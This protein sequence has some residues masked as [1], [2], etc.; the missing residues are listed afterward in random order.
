M[1]LIIILQ[2]IRLFSMYLENWFPFTMFKAK[3]ILFE[4]KLSVMFSLHPRPLNIYT[5]LVILPFSTHSSIYLLCYSLISFAVKKIGVNLSIR[6][7]LILWC[8][9]SF[10]KTV[11]YRDVKN[12][13]T[14]RYPQ[15]KSITGRKW[16]LKMDI[17][18]PRIRIFLIP[19]C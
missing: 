4:S 3:L 13:Y 8:I 16:I 18:Y 17:R 2:K 14:R 1:V 6:N 5:K 12:I 9:D 10:S 11:G 19:A 7:S 15:I